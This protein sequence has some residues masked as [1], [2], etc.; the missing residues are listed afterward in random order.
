MSRCH[1]SKIS[2]SQRSRGPVSMAGKKTRKIVMYDSSVHDCTQGQNGNP[3]FSSIVRQCK[4]LSLSRK[5]VEIQ[6]FCY[7]G[8][9]TSHILLY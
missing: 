8:N 9:L 5:I 1:R 2:R 3:Y 6:K 4:W 7:R